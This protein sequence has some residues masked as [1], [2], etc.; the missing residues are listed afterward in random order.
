M[1]ST[2]GK[3]TGNCPSMSI[4]L[5]K[6]KLN[7]RIQAR[8]SERRQRCRSMGLFPATASSEP[9]ATMTTVLRRRGELQYPRLMEKFALLVL[10]E[11]TRLATLEKMS[12]RL[13]M[14]HVARQAA[15]QSSPQTVLDFCKQKG[16]VTDDPSVPQRSGT[17]PAFLALTPIRELQVNP[18]STSHPWEPSAAKTHYRW[19]ALL[20]Q[21]CS[22]GKARWMQCVV[23]PTEET[24]RL[25]RGACACCT[26][27]NYPGDCSFYRAAGVVGKPA[28]PKTL[29]AKPAE[30]GQPG[31]S[32]LGGGAY[33]AL[34][35]PSFTR[36]TRAATAASTFQVAHSGH[37]ASATPATHQSRA[38]YQT[39][40]PQV[41]QS[42]LYDP[43]SPSVFQAASAATMPPTAHTAPGNDHPSTTYGPTTGTSPPPPAQQSTASEGRPGV[44]SSNLLPRGVAT[45]EEEEIAA[46]ETELHTNATRM[47]NLDVEKHALLIRRH[48]VLVRLAE[49][50]G[51]DLGI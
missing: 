2:R 35:A 36:T 18:Q 9:P 27:N 49:I 13:I 12:D 23:A 50:E 25:T 22:R 40:S 33:T 51:R 39:Q 20:T 31:H 15:P 24:D 1:D 48:A 43:T 34:Q 3:S 44:A 19:W 14:P 4:S 21:K 26:Y 16:Y 11:I 7:K 38:A 29:L 32:G 45:P 17:L 37:S 28:A 5:A 47:A 6:P 8:C 41:S 42:R 10:M 46:L 30:F